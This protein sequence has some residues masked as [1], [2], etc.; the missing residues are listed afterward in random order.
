MQKKI[1]NKK[2]SFYS[3]VAF[4]AVVF[5]GFL[6]LLNQNVSFYFHTKLKQLFDY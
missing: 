1:F 3:L 2:K 4:C 5:I 6:I